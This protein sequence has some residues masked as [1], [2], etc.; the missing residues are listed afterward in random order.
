MKK[1]QFTAAIVL[2]SLFAAS[3]TPFVS[4]ASSTPTLS[5][6][7]ATL[8]AVTYYING[9]ENHFTISNPQWQVLFTD[10]I[11][12]KTIVSYNWTQNA[13]EDL[14]VFDLSYSGLNP[15]GIDLISALSSIGSPTAENFTKALNKVANADSQVQSGSK[16]LTNIQA[17]DSGAYPGFSWSQPRVKSLSAEYRDAAIVGAIIAATFVLYFYFNRRK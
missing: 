6:P 5:L 9:T 15:F 1:I 3:F 11:N 4:A 16:T 8:P 14:I 17:L 12:N 13:T 2:L 10:V 7:P